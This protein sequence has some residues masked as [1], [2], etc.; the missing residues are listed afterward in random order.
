MKPFAVLILFLCAL[1]SGSCSHQSTTTSLDVTSSFA[2]SAAGFTGGLVVVA[3]NGSKTTTHT[4]TGGLSL[5]LSLGSGDWKFLVVGWDGATAFSGTAYCGTATRTIADEASL[6]VTIEVTSANCAGAEFLPGGGADLKPLKVYTCNGF[7]G[8]DLSAISAASPASVYTSGWCDDNAALPVGQKQTARGVRIRVPG[9]SGALDSGCLP[10]A[11]DP[12][13]LGR[14]PL[15]NVPVTLE[16]FDVADCSIVGRRYEFLT[17]IT[18]G[19]SSDVVLNTNESG[20]NALF[21]RF[22]Y[23]AIFPLTVSVNQATAQA[24]PV[25]ALPATF[26]AIFSRRI[27][28]ASFTAA[29]VVQSGTASGVSWTVTDSGDGQKFYILATSVGTSGTLIPTVPVNAAVDSYGLSNAASTA[30][31]SSVT[32]QVP[33]TVTVNQAAGQPDPT[34]TFGVGFDVVFNRPI[35]PGTFTAADIQNNGT[36]SGVTWNVST[37]DQTTFYVTALSAANPGTIVPSLP[38]FAA[39]DPTGVSSSASV[40]SDNSVTYVAPLEVSVNQASGQSDPT[41]ISPVTFDV[42][43]TAGISGASFVSSD[44]VHTGTATVSSWTITQLTA[45]TYTI[46]ATVTTPGTVLPQIPASAVLDFY[47]FPNTASSS[48]DNSVTFKASLATSP[49]TLS[50]GSIPAQLTSHGLKLTITNSTGSAMTGCSMPSVSDTVNFDVYESDCGTELSSGTSCDAVVRAKPAAVGAWA[51]AL[52]YDCSEA[53]V[54]STFNGITVTGTMGLDAASPSP[55]LGKVTIG[56]STT[57]VPVHFRSMSPVGIT[58]CGPVSQTN[59]AEFSIDT[60]GCSSATIPGRGACTMTVKGTPTTPGTRST[61]ISRTCSGQTASITVSMIATASPS[62]AL[63]AGGDITCMK[64]TDG[65]AHCWGFG[66]HGQLTNAGRPSLYAPSEINLTSIAGLAVGPQHICAILSDSTVKCW[67]SGQNG[68]IGTGTDVVSQQITPQTV[69]GSLSGVT[70]LALGGKFSCALLTDSTVR[71]WGLNSAGVFGNGTTTNSNVPIPGPAGTFTQ[72]TANGNSA[73]GLRSDYSV[74]CWGNNSTG[75]L[76][77]NTTTNSTIPVNVSGIT[78]AVE[79]ASGDGFHCAR[80]SDATVQ[81][82]GAGAFGQLGNGSTTN[83]LTPQ[84]VSG[85]TG[86]IGLAGGGAGKTNHMCAFSGSIVKCWGMNYLNQVGTGTPSA[87]VVSP[88]TV[89]GL[90]GVTSMAR[91]QNHTCARKSDGTTLCWGNNKDGQL[92]YGLNLDMLPRQVTHPS[93]SATV[94][95]VVLGDAATCVR[96][97]SQE[98][99]CWGENFDGQLGTGDNFPRTEA[100]TVAVSTVT[101]LQGN[102]DFNGFS[103]CAVSGGGIK[104]WGSNG[105][106]QLGNGN[107]TPQNTPV[108]V[109]PFSGALSLGGGPYHRCAVFVDGSMKC[110]GGNNYGQ[111]GNAS[112]TNSTTP[113]VASALT[114]ESI[115]SVGGGFGNTYAINAAGILFSVGYGVDGGLGD[116]TTTNTTSPTVVLGITNATQAIGVYTAACAVHTSGKVSCWGEGPLGIPTGGQQNAP[117]RVSSLNGVSRLAAG[118]RH[119]C[120]LKSGTVWCWGGSTGMGEL[121]TGSTQNSST[122]VPVLN[123]GTVQSLWEGE[124]ASQHSCAVKSDNTLWCWGNPYRYYPMVNIPSYVSGYAP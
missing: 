87:S 94:A 51:T 8:T 72:I 77:N 43:F 70:Q 41:T 119:V 112:I 98:V 3:A 122:P 11:S 47:G 67:G 31:D 19:L 84:V 86:I 62:D 90:T 76:G 52:T 113:V 83:A 36:A 115:M 33:L 54:T 59:S 81:C 71:C 35:Q 95:Q 106:G 114:S 2:I 111:L 85:L 34:N 13:A 92:G 9:V 26:E 99:Q 104:C 121:G 14:L 123:L 74:Q 1:I 12:L 21:L 5:R 57:S 66:N 124:A 103:L 68:E 75:Q 101:S 63:I 93:V 60:S 44:I 89:T 73:C 25:S 78:T 46:A 28:P 32:Y 55:N 64:H 23:A 58:G 108:T 17:G 27:S 91:G 22:Q 24:D 65:K 97:V 10:T 4:V 30:T 49:A 80:L 110:T 16:L 20:F 116:N 37:S 42:I 88:V 102:G 56:F 120:A 40:S 50:F 6:S 96:T 39:V 29:D 109:T 15:A 105:G 48:T 100:V 107:T 7:T 79:L 82:W 69:L 18:E 118:Q 117:V 61:T 45:S 38:A 53:L